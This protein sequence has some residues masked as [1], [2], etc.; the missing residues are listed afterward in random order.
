MKQEPKMVGVKLFD[1]KKIKELMEPIDTLQEKV[2]KLSDL[3]LDLEEYKRLINTSLED[4]EF[5]KKFNNIILYINEIN[6]IF[7]YIFH[8]NI[9]TL[10]GLQD[11]LI[12]K[13][14]AH[15]KATIENA[16]IDSR[17]LRKMGLYLIDKKKISKIPKKIT[18]VNSIG[19]NE[20]IELLD[21]LK[22][23]TMFQTLIRKLKPYYEGIITQ[24]LN[25]E[26]KD[27]PTN[28]E[29]SLILKFK[30]RFLI[31]PDITFKEYL[32]EYENEEKRLT[33]LKKESLV[34]W[35]KE[36]ENLE[37][38]KKK[39]EESKDEYNDYLKL[40]EKEFERKIRKK[41][42]EKLSKIVK[43]E[44]PQG[45]LI[46][47][48][49]I[50]KKIQKFKSQFGEKFK[51]EYL[52]REESNKDPIDLIRERKKRKKEEYDGYKDHFD[53]I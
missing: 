16:K 33:L 5:S 19:I 53:N 1:L 17:N 47:S 40:S 12:E 29:N 51:D 23:N 27:I 30:D 21:V 9:N 3:K 34:K 43:N 10:L 48:D 52:V 8:S 20:W 24:R 50:S 31:N 22:E 42:R 37:E 49:E 41:K 15:L 25:Y 28:I 4:K 44:L 14:K 36:K 18:Y 7:E 39:Q 46:I 6:K 11:N 2:N 32:N 38:L 45:E 13:N 26:L 35:R